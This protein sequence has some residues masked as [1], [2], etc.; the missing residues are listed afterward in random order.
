MTDWFK[1]WPS[2]SKALFLVFVVSGLLLY[3]VAPFKI[4]F[5]SFLLLVSVPEISIG[6]E[7]GRA[8][9]GTQGLGTG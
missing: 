6:E 5:K 1:P 2:G 7:A 4:I 8:R 3:I 9:D